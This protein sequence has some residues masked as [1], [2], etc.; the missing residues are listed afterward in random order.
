[1]RAQSLDSFA[2][3]DRQRDL[4]QRNLRVFA[5][6]FPAHDVLLWG[7]RGMGKSA[8]VRSAAETLDLPI[9]EIAPSRLGQIERLFAHVGKAER[10][11][12]FFIDDFGIDERKAVHRLRSVLDGSVSGRP[13]NI[14]LVVT[15]NRRHLMEREAGAA[16]GDV[17]A[18]DSAHD[19]L[20]LAERFGLSI[21]FHGASQDDYLAIC[22]SLATEHG[23]DEFAPED[24]LS[25]ARQRG[26][27][28]GRIAAHFITELIGRRASST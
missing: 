4:F 15:S 1:V 27:R 10:R 20:A 24:A 8:L 21:G 9:I 28:S 16:I 22:R 19:E 2:A 5:D 18:R 13:A 26:A 25:F 3:I 11:F 23:I 7:A 14:I 17:H 12:I 6:G